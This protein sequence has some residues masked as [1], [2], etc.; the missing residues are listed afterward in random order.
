MNYLFLI[1]G[2]VLLIKGADFF[3]SG[4]SRLAK[5]FKIPPII[6]GLTIVAFGTSSPEAA[7]SISAALRGTEG[8]SIGNVIGSN[9][10]NIS[11]I[12]GITATISPLIVKKTTIIKEIPFSLLGGIAL[13]ILLA[14]RLL[15]DQTTNVLSRADGL[16]LLAFFSIFLYYIIE[17]ALKNRQNG[18]NNQNPSTD[19]LED[20]TINIKKSIILTILGFAGIVLGGWL[21]VENAQ[22]IA[23]QLG[24]SETLVGL[25]IVAIGTSL[26]EMIT[27]I[28]AA[29][30]KES[31]IALG[32]IIGSN[33]FNI[34]FVLGISSTIIPLHIESKVFFD[35]T[36]MIVI[37]FVLMIF[38]TTHK[39]K[40][41]RFEGIMLSLIYISYL[42]FIIIRN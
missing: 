26:P 42:I 14:D 1:L 11:L 10:I 40:I 6:I 30:K 20:K 32:N 37:S 31:E 25:T 15:E 13:I 28:V 39:R 23:Q 17:V 35:I 19:P 21:V 5:Y 36:L 7:V 24:M 9:I 22:S 8:I 3:V 29:V 33:I 18:L 38:A 16:I 27:S 12:I 4:S 41:N 34:F 2:F